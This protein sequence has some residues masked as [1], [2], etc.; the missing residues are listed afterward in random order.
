MVSLP[1]RT[2]RRSQILL[3]SRAMG[4]R[5]KELADADYEAK[6]TAIFAECDR[7]LRDD[8]VMTVMFTHKR[9]EAWDTLGWVCSRRASQSRPPGR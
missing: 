1:T 8:G 5:K 6:M 4:S 9:A 3:D 2:T 7:V